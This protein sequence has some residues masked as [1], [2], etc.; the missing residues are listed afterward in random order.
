MRRLLLL[1]I[2][3]VVAPPLARAQ[4][5]SPTFAA[6]CVAASGTCTAV[7]G[8]ITAPNLTITGAASLKGGG[9]LLGTF[10]GPTVLSNVTPTLPAA[11]V[12]TLPASGTQSTMYWASDC[13][14]GGETVG[15]G[16]GCR[17]HA[18]NAGTLVP[19]TFP[20]AGTVAI[21]GGQALTWGHATANQ[22]NGPLILTCSGSF[23]QGNAIVTNA[24]GA[25]VDSGVVPS[26]GGGGGGGS[27]TVSAGTIDQLAWYSSSGT[28][29]AGL[30]VA[31]NA[32]LITSAGGVPSEATTLPSGITLPS[33]LVTTGLTLFGTATSSVQGNGLKVQ[34]STG[35]PVSG[36]CT[37]FDANGNTVDAGGACSIGGG[38]GTVTAGTVNQLAWYSSS[39]TSVA[40]LTVANNAVLVTSAGGVPSEATTLPSGLTMPS[41]IF[42]TAMS[43]F[44]TSL[45]GL[46]GNGAKMQL[47]TGAITS[48]HC[49]QFD[50]NG[51]TVDAGGSCTTGGGGGTVSAG[52]TNQIPFYTGTGT[53]L[54]PMAI[55][56]NAVLVTSGAG[57]PSESS[58]LPNGITLPAPL[59]TTSLSLFGTSV[60]AVQGTGPKVQLGAGTSTSGHCVQYDVNGN[61]VDAGG[62]CS[63]GAGTV[64]NCATAG[65]PAY[66]PS[67]GTAVG[68][69]TVVNNSLWSSNGSGVFLAVTTLP[70]SLTAPT[71]TLSSP[72]VTGAATV[73]SATFTGALTLA[74]SAAAGANFNCPATGVAP[75]S[76]ANGNIWC[77]STGLFDRFGGVTVG[78][79]IG[80]AQ[81]SGTGAISYNNTTGAFTCPLCLLATGTGGT[82]TP[83]AP[84]IISGTGAISLG[85]TISPV[86]LVWDGATNV[87]AQTYPLPDSWP[88]ATGTIDTLIAHT[89]GSSTPSFTV[90]LTINGT[91]IAGSC[92]TGVSISSG[93]DTTTSCAG[94][95]ITTGQKLAIVTS[96]IAGTPNTAVVQVNTHH[97]NP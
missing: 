91:P 64:T 38:G 44:G 42:T 20:P 5:P 40:G 15:N 16:T 23:V 13:L 29:V 87:T 2:L 86:E 52:T 35:A 94:A 75:T 71:W 25:C 66:Y 1:L 63:V 33:P 46:Q 48:G 67:A 39:G 82:L 53:T 55:A 47:S 6:I 70:A 4:F 88:W 81:L 60:T 77:A 65:A 73:S 12:A 76:P 79:L 27:G 61:T 21:I 24:A 49:V 97:S 89:G 90:A 80:L 8:Q 56:N 19:E 10:T 59:V 7:A 62:A 68:C 84:I 72:N 14:N 26:G 32:V 50:V 85:T 78:P 96:S 37:Q 17:Y 36:H 93:T 58:T 54:G 22:G 3:L 18:N 34:L 95:A 45:T 92:G 57:I 43:V 51:N 69:P 83:T 74:A 41:G 28:S 31:N 9:Q 30:A 11:T